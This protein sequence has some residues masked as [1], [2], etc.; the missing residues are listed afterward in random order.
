[1]IFGS[2]WWDFSRIFF[3]IEHPKTWFFP[4]FDGFPMRRPIFQ[5][6]LVAL[7]MSIRVKQGAVGK[8]VIPSF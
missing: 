2:P 8:L 6:Y 4:I 5:T 1:M 3:Q 7:E